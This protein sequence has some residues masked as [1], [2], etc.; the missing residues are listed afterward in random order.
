MY[1]LNLLS[2]LLI[3]IA[4]C[5]FYNEYNNKL[6]LPEICLFAIA[7]IAIIRASYNYI[8]ID[9]KLNKTNTY[10][11]FLSNEKGKKKLKGNK[12]NKHLNKNSTNHLT[13]NNTKDKF[14]VILNSEESEEYFDIENEQKT[15]N[16]LK[17]DIHELKQNSIVDKNAVNEVNNLFGVGVGINNKELFEDNN[18]SN[19]T[20]TTYST[21]T[22]KPTTTNPITTKPTT[23]KPTTTKPTPTTKPTT[24]KPTPTTK[25]LKNG[26]EIKSVFN[27]KIVIGKNNNGFGNTDNSKWN[28]AFKG[29]E[30]NANFYEKYKDNNKCEQYNTF[31][32]N[33][34]EALRVQNYN[35]AKKFVPGYTYVPPEN[36]SV[37]QYRPP[38]CISSSPNPLKL[39]GLVDRGLPLNVLEL[40]PQGE[41]ADTETDVSL[42]N[43]GSMMPNFKYEEEPFSRPYV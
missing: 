24:T 10:E 5:I 42:S 40:N 23:T 1:Q 31:S 36:W 2:L 25:L 30:F 41:V 19:T 27:P 12:N 16:K 21:T 8:E 37:P 33:T 26:D 7:F 3:V 14:D 39:T 32:S 4:L 28:D 43:V 20:S 9:N 38:V 22:T 6:T 29:A 11:S 13:K 34:D 18:N 15:I 35:D 17:Q